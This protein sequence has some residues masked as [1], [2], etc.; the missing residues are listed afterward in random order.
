MDMHSILN[1]LVKKGKNE[2]HENA[3]ENP[4][5]SDRLTRRN[6]KIRSNQINARLSLKTSL[7]LSGSFLAPHS[8]VCLKT[9]W[10]SQ[11]EKNGNKII[12][13]T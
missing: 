10:K 3:D 2:Q 8:S 1:K 5:N 11:T 7:G 6:E 13:N 9:K 4:L 12:E